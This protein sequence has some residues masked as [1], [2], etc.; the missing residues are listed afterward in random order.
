MSVNFK[1]TVRF[2]IK[3]SKPNVKIHYESAEVIHVT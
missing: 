2:T 1:I 3:I